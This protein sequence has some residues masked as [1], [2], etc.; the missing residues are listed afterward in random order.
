MIYEVPIVYT[1]RGV[2]EIKADNA[3]EARKIALEDCGVM[4]GSFHTS[5]DQKVID[6]DINMTTERHAGIILGGRH[7]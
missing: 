6:W 3:S 1:I 5:N 4:F 2:I 7:E